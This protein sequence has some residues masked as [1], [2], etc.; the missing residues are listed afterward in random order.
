[1]KIQGVLLGTI[2]EQIAGGDPNPID[3]LLV[4]LSHDP[5]RVSINFDPTRVVGKTIKVWREDGRILFAAEVDELLDFS[6]KHA[7]VSKSGRARKAAVGI[8]STAELAYELEMKNASKMTIKGGRLL[9]VGL[10]DENENRNQ[11]PFEVVE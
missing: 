3:P 10:T 4:R 9:E 5:Y 2:E 11:P 7:P 1:V 6:I 8:V